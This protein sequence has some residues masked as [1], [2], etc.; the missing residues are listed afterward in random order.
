M[1]PFYLPLLVILYLARSVSQGDPIDKVAELIKQGN[2]HELAKLFASNIEVT[3]LD[4]ENV[5]AKDQAELI[6]DKFFSQNKPRT[7]KMLHKINSNPNYRFGVLIVNTDKGPYR[8]AYTLKG[9]GGDLTMIEL[10]IETE[11]VK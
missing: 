8:V 11:K 4:D 2:V 5:Y 3:I 1:K 6:L 9:T 10:R 7:V